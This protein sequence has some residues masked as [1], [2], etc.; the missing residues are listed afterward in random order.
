[1]P[2]YEVVLTRTLTQRYRLQVEAA[3][4]TEATIR[5]QAGQ[6]D[7]DF[8]SG[9]TS[10]PEYGIEE[11]NALEHEHELEKIKHYAELQAAVCNSICKTFDS[12]PSLHPL[13][14]GP[15]NIHNNERKAMTSETPN[16]SITL[17]FKEGSSDKVYQA[18]ITPVRH[19]LRGQLRLRSARQHD[20]NRRQNAQSSGLRHRP[21]DLRQA[22]RREN[23]Q[24]LH[25][26]RLRDALPQT[27]LESRLPGSF[28]NS[29]IPLTRSRR[30]S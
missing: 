1:M 20:A 21:D 18:G 3:N 5:A 9:T 11:V 6:G 13:A 16:Q 25:P 19:R 17:Y 22:R 29:P 12:R 15:L 27:D 24:G 30:S 2:T 14:A 4:E 10:E 8:T 23:S 26:R 7:I 28:P